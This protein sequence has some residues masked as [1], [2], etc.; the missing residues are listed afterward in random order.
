[1]RALVQAIPRAAVSLYLEKNLAVTTV[2]GDTTLD[3]SHEMIP[4]L[5][6][7]RSGQ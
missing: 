6:T 7:A 1:M 5:L 3:T 4:V 2:G